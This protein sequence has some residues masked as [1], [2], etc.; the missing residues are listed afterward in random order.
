VTA[1]SASA[2]RWP[3]SSAACAVLLGAAVF[4]FWIPYFAKLGAADR[5]THF[6]V[7][8]MLCWML[9]LIAQPLLIRTGRRDAHRLLGKSS[10]LLAPLIIVSSLLL[11]HARIS[12]PGAMNQPGILQVL[13]LQVMSPL[14][15]TSFYLAGLKNRRVMSVH[16][17][18]MLAT[19][20]LLIDPIMAR[21][22]AFWLPQWSDA[23]EW[24][25]PLVAGLIL[26]GLIISERRLSA[27]RHV[28]P[29]VLAALTLQLVL[30]YTLGQ[31]R[32]WLDFA[33]WFAALPLT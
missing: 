9:L 32:L 19:G 33:T 7:A 15:F 26:L 23:G 1:I 30:F 29:L 2:V 10:L 11:A 28:F 27:G 17:R 16:S 4:G 13:V 6:H 8:T 20:M 18:W 24:A 14:L 25:G 22:L 31:S 21:I 12:Q 5:Y 3:A